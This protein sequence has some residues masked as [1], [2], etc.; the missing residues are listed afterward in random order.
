MKRFWQSWL[1]AWCSVGWNFSLLKRC[2]LS[3]RGRDDD[4]NVDNDQDSAGI[5]VI[6]SVGNIGARGWTSSDGYAQAERQ[7]AEARRRHEE[8]SR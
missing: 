5:G 7:D 8:T 6:G 3:R 4:A 2:L 1:D